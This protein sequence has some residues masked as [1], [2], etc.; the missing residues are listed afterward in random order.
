MFNG[1][2]ILILQYILHPLPPFVL[3]ETSTLLFI[4][5]CQ[6]CLKLRV[7][8]HWFFL[9]KFYSKRSTYS[10]KEVFLAL[11]TFHMET[12][13]TVAEITRSDHITRSNFFYFLCFPTQPST[14]K[15]GCLSWPIDWFQNQI[16]KVID[17]SVSQAISPF[18]SYKYSKTKKLT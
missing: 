14:W 16:F 9:T 13:I 11:M 12:N 10:F 8:F 18:C 4:T 15:V 17:I 3:K 6:Y 2:K 7:T 5:S 1:N